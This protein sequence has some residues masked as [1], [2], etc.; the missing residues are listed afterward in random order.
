VTVRGHRDIYFYLVTSI[1]DQYFLVFAQT[2]TNR[3]TDRQTHGQTLLK[4][5]PFHTA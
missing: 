5:H 2:N 1:Y 4:Q 3:Q